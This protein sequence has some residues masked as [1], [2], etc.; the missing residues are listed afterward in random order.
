MAVTIF[1][2]PCPTFGCRGHIVTPAV[3]IHD[4]HAACERASDG[5]FCGREMRYDQLE[6]VWRPISPFR[7]FEPPT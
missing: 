6:N 2:W 5:P 4:G 1:L 7:G 3:P